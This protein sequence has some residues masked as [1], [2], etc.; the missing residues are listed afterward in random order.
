MEIRFGTSG[1]RAVIAE[2][3]TFENVKRVVGSICRYLKTEEGNS[4]NTIIIGHD[5]R[6]MGERFAAVAA[7]I[8]SEYGFD[9]LKCAG[10]TPTPTMSHAIR[11]RSALGGSIYGL[12]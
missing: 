8:A 10:P 4:G 2:D 9:V 3:F 7:D 5:S 12:A 6:F 11:D 1:W